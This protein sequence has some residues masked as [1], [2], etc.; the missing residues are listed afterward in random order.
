MKFSVIK[1]KKVVKLLGVSLGFYL[2][3]NILLQNIYTETYRDPW[4]FLH[5]SKGVT[6]LEENGSKIVYSSG[7]NLH[8][9]VDV[10]N[11]YILKS[12]TRDFIA[13]TKLSNSFL[14]GAVLDYF[15]LN[16]EYRTIRGY[17]PVDSEE[18]LSVRNIYRSINTSAIKSL[19]ITLKW[20]S[21]FTG[22]TKGV[23]TF[24]LSR[25][26]SRTSRRDSTFKNDVF[27]D[28]VFSPNF[29]SQ[30]GW[31]NMSGSMYPESCFHQC[32]TDLTS[33]SRPDR[34]SVV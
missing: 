3:V 22:K 18:I 29:A 8:D 2:F 33:F 12:I 15:K 9:K 17:F 10:F 4:V 19:N 11:R 25:F 28:C 16:P 30:G 5:E 21:L 1:S 31:I 7:S 32:T 26:D 14:V 6:V 27:Y 34:K 13:P 24:V 20:F 23:E